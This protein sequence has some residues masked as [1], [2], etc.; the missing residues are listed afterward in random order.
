[1]NF[2]ADIGRRAG[3][4]E[5]LLFLVE[6]HPRETW[7]AHE[8]VAGMAAFWLQRHAMFR[9]VGG[10]LTDIIADYREGRQT[11]PEFARRF[12]P[13][14]QHFLGELDGHHNIED[15]HYFP[16]FA[17]AEKRLV[18]GFEILDADHHAIHTA[19][20]RNAEAANDFLR[21]L[22]SD[23]DQQRRKADAYA[24]ENHALVA[25]LARHL[26]DEEDL[27]IPLILDRGVAL[28]V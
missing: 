10:L 24:A 15:H 28:G 8:N 7:Q 27:I 17:A 9:E 22:S 19:L 16:V 12:A 13:R 25:M 14:L 21:A 11:A 5:D 20:E 6:K 4:P 3:L 23:A 2:D 1:M 18:R 26:D